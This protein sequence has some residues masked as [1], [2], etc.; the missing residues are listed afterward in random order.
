M[1]VEPSTLIGK[2]P[3]AVEKLLGSPAGIAQRD[4]SLIWTYGATDCVFQ[5]YFYPDIKTSMFH[6]LQFTAETPDGRK[7]EVTHGCIQHLLLVRK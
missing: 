4:V 7:V 6:A 2:E 3:S 5:V 1:A